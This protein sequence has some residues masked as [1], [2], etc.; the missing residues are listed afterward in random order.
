[1][2]KNNFK[3]KKDRKGT[4]FAAGKAKVKSDP[5][6][7]VDLL[8]SVFHGETAAL[9]AAFSKRGKK[10]AKAATK[11]ERT[12]VRGVSGKVAMTEKA[13]SKKVK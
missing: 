12:F 7:P 4:V 5:I 1:M 2:A 10:A 8:E 13:K 9:F 11:K 3:V 6:R